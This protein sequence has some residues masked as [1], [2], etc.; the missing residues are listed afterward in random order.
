MADAKSDDYPERWYHRRVSGKNEC[1]RMTR[2]GV[3]LVAA[4]AR[5]RVIGCD[6]AMPWH[7][8]A[9]LK[10]FKTVT[11]GHPVVMGRKTF[12]SIG[13]PLPGRKNVV[14]SR[15]KP[16]LPDG[17]M[18][19]SSLDQ[20]LGYCEG[21][22]EVMIIGGGEIYRQALPLAHR[23]ELTFVDTQVDGDTLFPDWSADGWRL[24]SM[25]ARPADDANPYRLTFCSFER[26]SGSA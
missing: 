3:V 7:L 5:N 18:L 17:V 10:H 12:E 16:K 1:T 19:A 13:K 4:M 9:D 24:V 23:M 20:A 2:N 8:P 22:G 6:G 15:G 14:I 25:E 26:E 11:M 21:A